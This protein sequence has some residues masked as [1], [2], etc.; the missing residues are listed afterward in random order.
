MQAPE[1]KKDSIYD[2]LYVDYGRI[3]SF[4]NQEDN[5]RS[6]EKN[7]ETISDGKEKTSDGSLGT[8]GTYVKEAL[9]RHAISS[10]TLEYDTYWHNVFMFLDSL[11]DINTSNH[12]H[13]MNT[14]DII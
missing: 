11:A 13:D 8:R 1:V 5:S 4:L 3:C 12:Q 6:L 7:Q 9:T 14:I 2:F 10:K